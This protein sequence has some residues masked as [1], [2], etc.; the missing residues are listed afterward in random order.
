MEARAARL[1]LE[2]MDLLVSMEY[3]V[4]DTVA[5]G[6]VIRMDPEPYS[7]LVENDI[8]TLVISLGPEERYTTVP[9]LT[10]M[11]ESEAERALEIQKSGAG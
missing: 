2:S 9:D 5:E 1:R 6:Y 8:V 7:E 3:E 4:S 11:T 10:D